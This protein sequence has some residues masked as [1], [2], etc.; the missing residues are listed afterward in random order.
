MKQ[1]ELLFILTPLYNT[2]ELLI[3]SLK[4]ALLNHALT[5]WFYSDRCVINRVRGNAQTLSEVALSNFVI[6]E[7]KNCTWQTIKWRQLNNVYKKTEIKTCIR[8]CLCWKGQ[9]I[10]YFIG[11]AQQSEKAEKEENQLSIFPHILSVFKL[12]LLHW[13]TKPVRIK[14]FK[15]KVILKLDNTY[16]PLLGLTVVQDHKL[17]RCYLQISL[18]LCCCSRNNYM[19]LSKWQLKWQKY[20]L[21]S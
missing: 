20:S 11:R 12:L 9:S 16:R 5:E 2:G 8:I 15:N 4:K 17:H 14:C 6:S 13:V 1:T 7:M 3:Q 21:S 18:L 19:M 10:L